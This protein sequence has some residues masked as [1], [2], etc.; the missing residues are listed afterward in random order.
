MSVGE[1]HISSYGTYAHILQGQTSMA[2][3]PRGDDGEPAEGG[4]TM[5]DAGGS[6]A[7]VTRGEGGATETC[8]TT[9]KVSHKKSLFR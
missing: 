6:A 1:L 3:P 2:A 7:T 5:V 4:D 8:S 9:Q